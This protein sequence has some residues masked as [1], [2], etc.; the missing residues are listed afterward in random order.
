MPVG[1]SGLEVN[2]LKSMR[3]NHD[4]NMLQ[5]RN[6]KT[7]EMLLSKNVNNN[8]FLLLI[9]ALHKIT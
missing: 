5:G 8:S 3:I 9:L 4:Q 7:T 6:V 2:A 1:R